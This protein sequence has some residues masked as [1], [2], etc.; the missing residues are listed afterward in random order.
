VQG[1]HVRTQQTILSFAS[2]IVFG[3]LVAATV[4]L[5]MKAMD[6]PVTVTSGPFEILRWAVV[7]AILGAFPGAIFYLQIRNGS[8]FP[9]DEHAQDRS[10][11]RE[12]LSRTNRRLIDALILGAFFGL[13][14]GGGVGGACGTYF[15]PEEE[16]NGFSGFFG[17]LTGTVVGAV[18]GLVMGFLFGIFVSRRS[19]SRTVQ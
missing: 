6:W 13:W 1:Y 14:V 18:S 12:E 10:H 9:I 16:I 2:G 17:A 15:E 7:G 8:S 19:A 5:V 4:F 3:V 11:Q